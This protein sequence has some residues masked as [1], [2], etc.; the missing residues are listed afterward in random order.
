MD[1]GVTLA[2]SLFPPVLWAFFTFLAGRVETVRPSLS[3]IMGAQRRRWVRNALLRESPMDAIL[4]GNLMRAVAFFASTTILIILALFA[5]FG[6]LET[7]VEAVRTIQ[8]ELTLSRAD[9]ELHLGVLILMFVLAFLSFTLSLRQFNHFCVMLGAADRS[10]EPDPDEVFVM[11]ALNALGGRNFNKGIHAY[12]FALGMLAW[13]VSPVASIA[14]TLLIFS[15]LFYREF[16]S[17]PRNLV[18]KLK[19]D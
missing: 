15:A 3:I 5:V 17:E 13:F 16:Y 14:L 2:G 9:V 7:V 10:G 4:S 19:V 12:Y 18:A 1:D 11:A 8:P 6:Q